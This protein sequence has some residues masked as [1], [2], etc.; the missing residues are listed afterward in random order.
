MMFKSLLYHKN[1]LGKPEPVVV[2]A[3][4]SYQ[5]LRIKLMWGK[6]YLKLPPDPIEGEITVKIQINKYNLSTFRTSGEKWVL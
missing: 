6:L 4:L 2:S 3:Y 5:I 1:K